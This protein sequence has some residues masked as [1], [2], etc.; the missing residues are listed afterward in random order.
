M[1]F[2]GASLYIVPALIVYGCFQK[3]ML[4]GIQLSGMK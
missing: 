2:S 1:E 4:D 3:S